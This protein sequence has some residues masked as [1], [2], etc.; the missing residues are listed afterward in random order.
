MLIGADTYFVCVPPMSLRWKV[1]GL[2]KGLQALRKLDRLSI[3]KYLKMLKIIFSFITG[4]DFP[5]A[6]LPTNYWH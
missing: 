2:G 6:A 1:I 5:R 4:S 3:C